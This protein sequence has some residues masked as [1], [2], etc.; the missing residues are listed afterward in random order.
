MSGTPRQPAGILN[1]LKPPGITSHGVVLRL[2]RLLGIR[3][4]GHGGTLDPGAAGVLP[5][6]VGA[7]TKLMPY[8]LEHPKRYRAEMTLGIATDTQDA[9]GRPVRVTD[10]FALDLEALEGALAGF[11]GRIEQVPP[12]TSAVRVG[13]ERLYERARRGECVERPSRQVHVYDVRVVAVWPPG[14]Q[15]LV[16]GTRVL[17]EVTCS[18]GTYVRTLCHDLGERLGCGAHMSFLVRTDVGPFTLAESYTLEELAALN[19]QG[20]LAECLLPLETAL[21]HLPRVEVTAA[22]AAR[23]RQGMRRPI[24]PSR[25]E[26]PPGQELVAAVE[27][28]RGLVCVARLARSRERL[29]LQPVRVF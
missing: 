2:R 9:S 4:I 7:A 26:G 29:Q 22:E 17:L 12:M 5:V 10:D 24:E 23:L 8:L 21:A 16:K 1:V 13:G 20:R 14:S 11:V 19:A 3:T 25:I 18:K 27:A 6:L 28:G 15:A